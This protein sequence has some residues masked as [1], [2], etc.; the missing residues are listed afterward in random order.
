M[1]KKTTSFL[2]Q[3]FTQLFLCTQDP[4]LVPGLDS[5]IP[6]TVLKRH[7]E[8]ALSGVIVKAARV[9][10]LARGIV[11][12]M[13][14]AFGDVRPEDSMGEFITWCYEVSREALETALESGQ[15]QQQ[16]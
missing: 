3:F 11:Y 4:S 16:D 9:P 12:F 7:D 14:K 6:D 15:F 10:A 1:K 2:L 5:N 8:K 13:A